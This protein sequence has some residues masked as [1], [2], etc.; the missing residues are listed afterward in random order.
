M[1]LVILHANMIPSSHTL[2]RGMEMKDHETLKQVNG[3][4]IIKYCLLQFE[5]DIAV[6]HN[7]AICTNNLIL[8]I[9]SDCCLKLAPIQTKKLLLKVPVNNCE[10][11]DD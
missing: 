10:D 3:R 2:T 5:C 6:M 8:E 11:V 9:G 1:V 7:I 4:K